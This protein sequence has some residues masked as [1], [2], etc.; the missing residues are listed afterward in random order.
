MAKPSYNRTN[1]FDTQTD[2]NGIV[3]SDPIAF[4]FKE[5][6]EFMRT[7]RIKQRRISESEEGAPDLISFQEYGSEQYWWVIM[8]INKIQDPINELTAGTL[9]AIPRLSDV[10]EFRQSRISAQTRGQTVILR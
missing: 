6:F 9:L 8:L 5:F 3:S 10:E 1:F 2:N 7:K 4:D